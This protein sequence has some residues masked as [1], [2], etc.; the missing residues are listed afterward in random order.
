[1][2]V[3]ICQQV[4][5]AITHTKVKPM[6]E[7]VAAGLLIDGQTFFANPKIVLGPDGDPAEI[8]GLDDAAVA[9]QCTQE[10]GYCF[11]I[12]PH[13]NMTML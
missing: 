2:T 13:E 11:V 1:M 5:V 9:M 4:D 8:S 3:V 7:L 10:K 6:Q 12:N